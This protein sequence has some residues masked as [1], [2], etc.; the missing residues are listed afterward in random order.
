MEK[1]TLHRALVELKLIGTKI[2][3]GI[4]TLTVVSAIQKDKKIGNIY[5]EEEFSTNAKADYQSVTDLITRR[6]KIKTLVV[7][8]NAEVKVTINKVEMTI[9]DAINFKAVIVLKQELLKKLK[10]QYQN[11]QAQLN[12]NNELID[13]QAL[14][15]VETTMGANAG[16]KIDA[17]SGTAQAIMK[18]YK[19]NNSFKLV[20]PLELGKE[21]KKLEDEVL[22]FMA[23]VDA[24]L[25]EANAINFIEI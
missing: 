20:D 13:A 16:K 25:S 24:V 21:I 8:K 5:T 10:D 3:K 6:N 14:K 18:P 17:D 22:G 7:A 12:R 15:L 19:E 23:E 9:A 4:D 2:K 1:M 11:I